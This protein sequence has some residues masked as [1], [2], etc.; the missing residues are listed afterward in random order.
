MDELRQ[1]YE[2]I[3]Y[4]RAK[5]IKMK[6]IAESTQMVPSVLSALYST[7]LPAYVKNRDKGMDID[8]A[9]DAS[10]VWVNNISK[11]KLLNMLPKL[12]EGIFNVD[13]TVKSKDT[14][15]VYNPQNEMF[16]HFRTKCS[17]PK[18]KRT[19]LTLFSVHHIQ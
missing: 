11:K 16:W 7:V 17:F 3:S 10:L 6:D 14:N 19:S 5:G 15:T 18:T 4:L 9:L 1:I 13:M 2:R 12:K 8:D